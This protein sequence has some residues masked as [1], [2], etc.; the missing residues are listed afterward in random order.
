MESGSVDAA[1]TGHRLR[2]RRTTERLNGECR[3]NIQQA[4]VSSTLII[5]PHRLTAQATYRSSLPEGSIKLTADS[6]ELNACFNDFS[7]DQMIASGSS[8]EIIRLQWLVSDPA[9]SFR[10]REIIR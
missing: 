7:C 8:S 1:T 2:K 6:R 5:A 9:P 3:V 4:A 10:F